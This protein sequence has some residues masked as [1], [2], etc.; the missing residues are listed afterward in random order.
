MK[1]IKIIT[2]IF[3]IKFHC[4]AEPQVYPNLIKSKPFQNKHPDFQLS[5]FTG[6][7]RKGWI[8]AGVHILEGAFQYV[9]KLET[10]MFLPKLPGKSYPREGNEKASQDKRSAAI[11]EAIARTFNVA[12]P[13]LKDNPDL[14]NQWHSFGGLLQI[15]LFRVTL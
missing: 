15:S 13:I 10:P 6:L 2:L 8:E 14:K 3:L 5:P 4:F 1:L 9:D 11:F 7:D 12:A